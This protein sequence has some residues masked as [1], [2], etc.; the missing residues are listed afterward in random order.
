MFLLSLRRELEKEM[1]FE[2]QSSSAQ[3]QIH[4]LSSSAINSEVEMDF[5]RMA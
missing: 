2:A 4:F 5:L 1:I 3:M